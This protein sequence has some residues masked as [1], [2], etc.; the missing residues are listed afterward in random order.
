[1]LRVLLTSTALL[2]ACAGTVAPAESESASSARVKPS[3]PNSAPPTASQ[4]EYW[5]SHGH[6][7][8]APGAPQ[9]PEWRH[10]TR[11]YNQEVERVFN[12]LPYVAQM[13]RAWTV[14][15]YKQGLISREV[16]V[17]LLTA[18]ESADREVGYGGEDWLK[19]KLG[20]DEDTASAVNLGRTLQEPMSRLQQRDKMIDVLDLM[21]ATL[22]VT[23]DVA[24]A[25]ADTIMAG[26]THLSHAQ[27]TT[28]G[29]YLLSVHD[30]LARGLEQLELAYKHANENSAGCGA[31]AGT[32][33]PVDRRMITELLGL[34]SLVEP[35]YD[36]EAG[37]D[38]PLTILFALTNITTVLSRT[39][40]DYNIWGME[41]V[42][43]IRVP[44][45]W[46]GVSSMMPQKAIP[47][48]QF[49]RIRIEACNV[50][51][52]TITG[53]V[54][55]KGEPHSDMLPIYEGYRG[56]LRALCHAEKA[57]G[58]FSSLLPVV[59]P[60][61]E[62]ML[63]LA[64]EGYSA[65]PDLAVK[66]IRDKQ[67]GGR[68]AHRICATFVRIARE[69]GIKPYETT[70]ELLDE[71]ARI[72]DEDPPGLSTEEVRRLLDPVEFIK[73]HDNLGDPA[74]EETRRMIGVRRAT[75]AKAKSRHAERVAR[76]EEASEKLAAEIAAILEER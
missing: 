20:G 43:M 63:Q 36:C 76:L 24:E 5:R 34:D 39:A 28:Y 31:L 35:A 23:L 62:R 18:L 67:Y 7:R 21:L 45:E 9:A 69:R 32:G 13:D 55:C 48:S 44:P 74:P 54:S 57:L 25:N 27:P 56:A 53:V 40:M 70:G 6:R 72:V 4:E 8:H 37:Q 73:R 10:Y 30:G 75:L 2:A 29:A 51:G 60:D 14:M 19:K 17:K 52:E 42:A 65:T 15:L 33:W 61:K 22:E 3:L 66:L 68:R 16:A 50:I 58:F 71:A 12:R 59:Q 49:E 41:E 1:M 46:C 64:R 38:H 26:Q 47:G 11:R